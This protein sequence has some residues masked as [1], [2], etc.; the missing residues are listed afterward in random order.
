[1]DRRQALR[2][3]G[4]TTVAATATDLEG[5]ARSLHR[6]LGRGAPLQVLDPH[7]NATVVALSD[8]ILPATDTP[9][10]KAARVN[11][12]IDLLLAEW[13]EPEDR[14]R[15]LAGLADVDARAH[16]AFGKDFVDGTAVDQT[17]LLTALD[18]AAA[19][20]NASP[21]ATRGRQPFYREFKWLTLFAYYTSD[22]G[23]QQEQHYAI[24][25][26]NYVPCAPADTTTAPE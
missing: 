2:L 7:Q 18:A 12:F 24:V 1:M 5:V 3:L 10:A 4:V 8:A 21:A 11:E 13:Y 19:R 26:G 22:I 16:T 17:A 9:G 25:P 15:L 14:D 6:R 23:A 20:W